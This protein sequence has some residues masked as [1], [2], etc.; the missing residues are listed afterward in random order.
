VTENTGEL[1]GRVAIVT[2][3]SRGIGAAISHK[4]ARAGAMLVVVGRNLDTAT[5]IA[6]QIIAKGGRAIAIGADVKVAADVDEVVRRTLASFGRID[7]LI[8]NAGISPVSKELQDLTEAEWDLVLDVNLKGPFLLCRG[9]APAMI[10]AHRGVIVNI[11]S[12]AGVMP[13]PLESAYSASKSGLIGL[14]KALAFDWAKYGIRVHAVAPGYIATEMNA[15]VRARGESGLASIA[16]DPAHR[17]PDA[18]K[19]AVSL[20]HSVTGRTLAGRFG[21]PD[22]VAEVVAFLCTDRASFMNG[23]VTHVDGGWTI[24]EP[25]APWSR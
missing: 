12:I 25:P 14:T 19:A 16:G 13:I 6:G 7:I 21:M 3:G 10:T 24:G 4:L 17:I 2:G 1:H 22:E 5:E 8:N 23:A 11:S 20:Y 18:D 9:V 15:G